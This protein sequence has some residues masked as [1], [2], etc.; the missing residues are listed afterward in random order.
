MKKF[1]VTLMVAGTLSVLAGCNKDKSA[2]VAVQTVDWYKTHEAERAAMLA[3]CQSNP[4]ELAATP[5]C[6]NANS[7]KE[8][9]TWSADGMIKPKPLKLERK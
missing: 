1:T 5:N 2:E 3:K 6:V 9:I 4:G 7:A 8:S